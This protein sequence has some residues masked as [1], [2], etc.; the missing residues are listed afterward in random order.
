MII[1]FMKYI[2]NCAVMRHKLE[3][4]NNDCVTV[5][6]GEDKFDGTTSHQGTF[7]IFPTPRVFQVQG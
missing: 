1:I 6:S 4:S 2:H 3:S 5:Y 7:D